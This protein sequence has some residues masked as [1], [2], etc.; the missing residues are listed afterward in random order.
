[1]CA[2]D[3]AL[4]KAVVENGQI[5]EDVDGWGVEHKCKDFDA[6]YGFAAERRSNNDTGIH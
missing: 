5:V 6:I 2:G 3:S 4:E 1:M